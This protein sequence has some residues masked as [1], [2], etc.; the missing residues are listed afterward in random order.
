MKSIILCADDYGQNTVISQAII[1]LL[2]KK[3][4]SA[5][6]CMTNSY[7][8]LS[9]A[10]WLAPVSDQADIGLHFN[11]T[12][13]KPLSKGFGD[14]KPVSDL[15]IQAYLR[16]LKQAAIETELYAQLDQ[17]VAGMGREPDFIDGHQH[18]QQL[19]V[20]RDAILRVYEKRLQKTGCYLRCVSDPSALTR[21]RDSGYLKTVIVQLCGAAAFKKAVI[22][23]N[24]PHNSSFAGFYDFAEGKNYPTLFPTFLD[25]IKDRGLI[26]CHP[27]LEATTDEDPIAQ[28][29]FFEYTYFSSDQFMEDCTKREITLG[30]FNHGDQDIPSSSI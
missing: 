27:G 15:I 4:L 19:P 13:G 28:A 23:Q 14:F 30:R 5:T 29:R 9:H 18:I 26:M 17:F 3:R 7:Y 16:R 25:L 22:K 6:S 20:I 10:K 21:F 12:E 24:I 2:K 11:L 1:E 8:W